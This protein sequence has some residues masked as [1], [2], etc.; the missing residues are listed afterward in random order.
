MIRLRDDFGDELRKAQDQLRLAEPTIAKSRATLEEIDARLAQ[1]D[2]PPMLLDA[3]NEIESLQ[4]R[5]GAVEKASQD[6]VRL[7]TFQQDAEHQ[8]RRILR[9]LARPIDLDEAE[10]LRLRADEPIDDPQA[11]TAVRPDFAVRLMPRDRQSPAMTIKSERQEK[12]LAELE[13]PP[14]VEPLRR[15]VSQARKAG[16]LDARL[17]ETRGQLVLAEK[18]AKTAL[19]QLPGW[20]RSAEDLGQ[21]GHPPDATLDQFES[22]AQEMARQQRSVTERMAA[23]DESIR[24]L[25]SRLQSLE[26]EHDVPTE[27]VLLAARRPPRGRLAARQGRLARPRTRGRGP[28]RVPRRVCAE[29][30]TRLG[31]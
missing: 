5:L 1:L 2:P 8:A 29:G 26:L 20:T 16:D 6:R 30:N 14:D 9:D 27:E 19:A 3:A 21:P 13:Q 4:E 12:E 10:T 24:E 17:G 22:R 25:E 15:A 7:E 18:K 28:R 31:L 11:G 23:E